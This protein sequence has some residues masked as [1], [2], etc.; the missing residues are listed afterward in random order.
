MVVLRIGDHVQRLTGI[1]GS[2]D[3]ASVRR[4]AARVDGSATRIS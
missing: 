2:G 4:I 1:N 3:A